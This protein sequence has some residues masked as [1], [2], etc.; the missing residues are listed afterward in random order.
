M[1]LVNVVRR[2]AEA[3][4]SPVLERLMAI[5][6][7]DAKPLSTQLLAVRTACEAVEPAAAGNLIL[8]SLQAYLEGSASWTSDVTAKSAAADYVAFV[9]AFAYHC[10]P[11]LVQVMTDDTA[12]FEYLKNLYL[13]RLH[14]LET[15]EALVQALLRCEVSSRL[16]NEAILAFLKSE[17]KGVLSVPDALLDLLEPSAFPLLREQVRSNT[18]PQ[19]FDFASAHALSHH[20]DRDIVGDLESLRKP[21]RET[22]DP[23]F[24]HA[25]STLLRF[26]WRI[27]IQNPPE[28]L[29]EYIA[30]GGRPDYRD[31]REYRSWAV[32]RAFKRGIDPARVREAILEHAR[33]AATPEERLELPDL[34]QTGLKLGIL[35]AN[36]LPDVKIHRGAQTP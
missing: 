5:G 19:T 6:A 27:E 14:S 18:T 1:A 8:P 35:D 34:K 33:K 2:S 31:S 23:N 29:L 36:D 11:R 15:H 22:Q 17:G 3:G 26:L 32:R 10:A 13:L 9:Y 21:F 20:G 16:R 30:S 4:S 7:D 25:E 12:L 24:R 28:K